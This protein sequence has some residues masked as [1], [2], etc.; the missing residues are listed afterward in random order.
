MLKNKV[1]KELLWDTNFFG[2]KVARILPTRLKNQELV[3]ALNFLHK[4]GNELIYWGVDP[5]DSESLSAASINRGVLVDKKTTFVRDCSA[6]L[7]YE[8]REDVETLKKNYWSESLE[9]LAIQIG[10]LSRFR[11][12]PNFTKSVWKNLYLEWMKNSVNHT[13]SDDVLVIRR[14]F[15]VV[16]IL[17]V[18]IKDATGHIGLLGVDNKWQGCGLGSAITYAALDWFLKRNISKVQVVTQGE[19]QAA[20]YL[21]KKCGFTISSI[22]HTYHFWRK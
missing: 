15:H 18:S 6:T 10:Y 3:S 5:D 2:F 14:N 13:I 1:I 16:A 4:K 22:E 12:D 17:T 11:A 8:S 9:S 7:V 20:C 19:N 21:Y